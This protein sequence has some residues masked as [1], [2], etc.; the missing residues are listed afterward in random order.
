MTDGALLE[1]DGTHKRVKSST[2]SVAVIDDTISSPNSAY[3]SQKVD[4]IHA[5]LENNVYNFTITETKSVTTATA[6][7]V[8]TANSSSNPITLVNGKTNLKLTFTSY[9]R[10]TVAR[11][12]E[13]DAYYPKI[14]IYTSSS[15]S[16][17]IPLVVARDGEL[18]LLPCHKVTSGINSSGYYWWWNN[19]TSFECVYLES[20]EV[21]DSE[22]G[23]VGT[24]NVLLIKDNPVVLNH[25]A[26]LRSYKVYA[27]GIKELFGTEKK[28]SY[29]IDA[30]SKITFPITFAQTYYQFFITA[31]DGQFPTSTS[32]TAQQTWTKS[33]GYIT[34]TTRNRD[35]FKY[36]IADWYA[37]G[38]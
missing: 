18:Y 38:Y 16:V 36:K 11:S 3:S 13:S 6:S 7:V 5:Q 30:G 34:L 17:N 25:K 1:W 21:W 4:A 24:M 8:L 28:S 26:S 10:S 37:R 19:F 14:K 23:L 20:Q 9:C 27:D 31:I 15:A 2:R 22:D 32:E 35:V 29:N 33:E 12:E